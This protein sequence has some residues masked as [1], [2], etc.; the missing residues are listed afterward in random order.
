MAFFEYNA[1]PS[2]TFAVNLI[3]EFILLCFITRLGFDYHGSLIGIVILTLTDYLFLI[4]AFEDR[5]TGTTSREFIIS[6]FCMAV[7]V[8]FRIAIFN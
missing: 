4:A 3:V 6:L 1:L 2:W 8:I 5:R 7:L